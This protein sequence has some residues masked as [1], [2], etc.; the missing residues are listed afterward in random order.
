[1]TSNGMAKS[2]HIALLRGI[3]VGGKNLLPMKALASLFTN[4]GCEDVRTYIQSGN[5]VF[6]ADAKV[7]ASLPERLGAAIK[8]AYGF[9][10]PVVLRSADEL[11]RVVAGNPFI[12]REAGTL[13]VV[14]LAQAPEKEAASSLEAKPPDEFALKEREIYLRCPN[15]YGKTKLTNA[16]FD[17]RLKTVSTVRNWK[18]VLT[19]LEMARA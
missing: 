1:M 8:R 11:G 17:A 13:H 2:M 3:N 14:F 5:A 7:A 18:T 15:G 4:A 12:K 9:E 16:Y 19:L 10:P 6:R